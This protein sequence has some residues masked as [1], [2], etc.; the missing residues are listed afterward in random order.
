MLDLDLRLR[1]TRRALGRLAD[2]CS[3][4]LRLVPI[5]TLA[6][7]ACNLHRIGL[8]LQQREK[9]KLERAKRRKLKR[10]AA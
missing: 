6:V 1:M 10:L 3:R 7:V 4:L 2:G 8:V 9:A 5:A